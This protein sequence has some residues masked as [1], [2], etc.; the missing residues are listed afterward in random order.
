[1][2]SA[3][4]R[5]PA[6]V[7][8]TVVALLVWQLVGSFGPLHGDSFASA[9]QAITGLSSLARQSDF[10]S[11]V[12]QTVEIAAIGFGISVLIAVPL[13]VVI[14]LSRFAYRS[15][16]F[17]FDFFKVIPPI[18]II[19]IAILAIGPTLEMGIFLVVFANIFS[20]AI[21]TAYGVRDTD[22]VLLETMKCYRMGTWS[23]IRY[24]R[25]P[26]AASQI[27]VALRLA[28]SASLIVAVVA[29]LIGGAPGLGQLLGLLENAG[30][31]SQ[32]YGVVLFLGIIGL[33]VSRAIVLAQRRMVFWS[34]K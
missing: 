7:V 3:V 16:K 22:P 31:T 18:V 29:S 10:W 6:G 30:K 5:I 17:T 12:A 19:P 25:L 9:S 27:S 24:A 1:V 15:T 26:A 14:G 11:A 20:V 4:S 23:Q 28:A 13:G 8:T 34:G 32:A 2:K 21:Q 33:L